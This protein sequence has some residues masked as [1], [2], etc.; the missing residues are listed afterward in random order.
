M[1]LL[2]A[3]FLVAPQHFGTELHNPTN[4]SA[5]DQI[6]QLFRTGRNLLVLPAFHSS[7][8]YASPEA[9]HVLVHGAWCWDT[10]LGYI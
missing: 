7:V 3:D 6:Y 1:L 4:R 9:Q 2:D 8:E 5:Y 10:Y